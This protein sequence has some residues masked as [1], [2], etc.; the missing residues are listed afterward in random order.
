MDM[1]TPM[2]R[3]MF[4]VCAVFA[5]IERDMIAER[6]REGLRAARARGVILGKRG[7]SGEVMDRI[8]ELGSDRGRT[9][10]SIAEE[11]GVSSSVVHRVLEPYREVFKRRRRR[12]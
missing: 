3:G 4:G 9:V 7:V 10:R 6:T 2:G 12:G 5:Q 11:V 1:G 8:I